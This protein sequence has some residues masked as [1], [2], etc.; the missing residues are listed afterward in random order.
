MMLR[1]LA[2]VAVAGAA[3][4]VVA[5]CSD[6]EEAT[7]RAT[8]VAKSVA[9]EVSAAATSVTSKVAGAIDRL[10]VPQAQTILTT[11]TNPSTPVSDLDAVVDADA[12]TKA[13]LAGFNKSAA[14]HGYT[15]TVTDV[16]ATGVN[17]ANVDISVKSP[18]IPMPDGAPMTLTYTKVDGTWKLT[19]ESANS[20][21]AQGR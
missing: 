12:A 17:T 9:S 5:G 1:K 2:A 13:K 3:V 18:H 6:T 15:F 16:K 10:D 8:S 14:E 11:A 20:L 21:I 4:F 19:T 7:D